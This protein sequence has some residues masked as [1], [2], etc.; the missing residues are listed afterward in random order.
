[1]RGVLYGYEGI[2]V[3]QTAVILGG[4]EYPRTTAEVR[5]VVQH[6]VVDVKSRASRISRAGA[7][8]FGIFNS[9]TIASQNLSAICSDCMSIH[10]I[11]S[12]GN[13]TG[14]SW[15]GD[16]ARTML[17][18]NASASL[19]IVPDRCSLRRSN[20]DILDDHRWSFWFCVRRDITHHMIAKSVYTMSA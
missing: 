3:R 6:S 1:M 20:S 15:T 9:L 19:F 7:C 18:D 13:C 2:P 11:C 12:T 14:S 8:W 17:R 10:C 16:A 4:P 5:V